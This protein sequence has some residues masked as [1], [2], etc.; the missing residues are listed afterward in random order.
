RSCHVVFAM[1]WCR[2]ERVSV[3]DELPLVISSVTVT[4]CAAVGVFRFSV[5]MALVGLVMVYSAAF[6]A[7][8][9]QRNARLLPVEPLPL[10]WIDAGPVNVVTFGF[11]TMF[12]VMVGGGVP[13]NCAS[14]QPWKRSKV[15]GV[16]P[17][18]A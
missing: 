4:S 7:D 3:S 2:N 6:G 14:M 11:I 10:S 1:G 5:A 18:S 17:H 12:A 16:R 15:G 8:T 9:L 13:E